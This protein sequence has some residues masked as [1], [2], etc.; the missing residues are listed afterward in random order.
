MATITMSACTQAAFNTAYAASSAGDTII[1]PTGTLALSSD[2]TISGRIFQGPGKDHASP[3]NVTGGGVVITKH[4]SAYTKLIGF[5]FTT[6]RQHFAIGGTTT[7]FAFVV[8][9]CYFFNGG[10]TWA[11]LTTNGGLFYDCEFVASPA[12][13]ADGFAI[14][15]GGVGTAGETSWQNATTF[16]MDDSTGLVNTYF[17]DCE[18]TGF[19]EVAMDVD[20]GARVAVRHCIFNDSSLVLHGGGNGA[21][22]QDT[23]AYGGR[24]LEVYNCTFNRVT[25]NVAV[26]K[27]IWMRGSSGVFANNAVED[28]DTPDYPDKNN[29][30]FSVGCPSNP[31]YPMAYQFGQTT[32]TPDATPNQPY[33]VFG[34]TGTATTAPTW[35]VLS[36]DSGGGIT[37]SVP[38]TYIQSGRDYQTS[39]TWGWV[40]YT[41]PHPLRDSSSDVTL[42]VTTANITTLMLG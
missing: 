30:R 13:S 3:V 39:N 37:C 17:E 22:G 25:D 35:I 36:G 18:W 42:N 38:S 8:G 16:G 4:A 41:Y 20:N 24:Q 23:S 10:A 5:R 34:N 2:I 19:L 15:L 12:N 31:G 11:A 33:L 27:W 29:L 7:N 6:N 21:G 14:N 1:C 32:Q 40:P 9:D 26:N 28:N